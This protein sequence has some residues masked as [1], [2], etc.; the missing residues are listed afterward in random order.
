MDS[1]DRLLS[2]CFEQPP[3][4]LVEVYLLNCYPHRDLGFGHV[5]Y[6]KSQQLTVKARTGGI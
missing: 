1:L 6:Y 4:T 5:C 3:R 2:R